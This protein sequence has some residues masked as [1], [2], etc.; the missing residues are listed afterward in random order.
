[1]YKVA[2]RFH[3][4]C[5]S[6]AGVLAMAFV[7]KVVLATRVVMDEMSSP[8]TSSPAGLICMTTVCVFA[9]RGLIGQLFV[10]VAAAV[11]LCLV[12]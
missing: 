12:S 11:H 6:V 10:S 1:V 7:L 2:L 5:S 4:A 9:G 3:F 8:T